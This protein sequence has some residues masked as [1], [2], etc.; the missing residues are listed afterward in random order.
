M[1]LCLAFSLTHLLMSRVSNDLMNIWDNMADSFINQSMIICMQYKA[2]TYLSMT[3]LLMH[4]VAHST[5]PSFRPKTN[6]QPLKKFLSLA[7]SCQFQKSYNLS[8]F[9]HW[10]IWFYGHTFFPWHFLKTSI[11]KPLS[12][13]KWRPFFE[14]FY[15]TEGK[16]QNI[17]KWLVVG[18]GPKGMPGRMCDIGRL[19]WVHATYST[20]Y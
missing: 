14:D 12:F 7:V 16:T 20:T 6:N 1:L 3:S 4:T 17:F 18:F 15:S 10:R 19:K 2:P 8:I 13:L 9:F 11:F 5:R